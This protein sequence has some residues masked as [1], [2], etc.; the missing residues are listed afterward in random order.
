ME[1]LIFSGIDFHNYVYLFFE[2]VDQNPVLRIAQVLWNLIKK[3]VQS[4]SLLLQ[5]LIFPATFQ[6]LSSKLLKTFGQIF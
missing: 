5:K 3:F 6:A 2:T 1:E 4:N